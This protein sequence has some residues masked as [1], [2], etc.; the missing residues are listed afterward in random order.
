[1]K[2]YSIVFLLCIAVFAGQAQ[3]GDVQKIQALM[4]QQVTAWNQ[5]NLAAFMDTYWN[6]DSLLFVGKNGVTYGWQ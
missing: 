4:A 2:K 3:Q 6:S 5:G 1:M